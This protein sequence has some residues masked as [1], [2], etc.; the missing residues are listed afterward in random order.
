MQKEHRQSVAAKLV[1]VSTCTTVYRSLQ[2]IA[3]SL[4][5]ESNGNLIRTLSAVMI[6]AV[7]RGKCLP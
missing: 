3:V 6:S 1:N 4:K 5:E 2:G 7:E